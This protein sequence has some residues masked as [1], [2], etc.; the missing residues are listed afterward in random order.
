MAFLLGTAGAAPGDLEVAADAN[1]TSTT[2]LPPPVA[3]GG[4]AA[5]AC[6]IAYKGSEASRGGL[7]LGG[8]L[9]PNVTCVLTAGGQAPCPRLADNER[10]GFW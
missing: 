2:A 5:A 3:S 7:L 8:V 4:G 6:P 10:G 1:N 9:A